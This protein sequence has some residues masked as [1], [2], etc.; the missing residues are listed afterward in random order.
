V[1]GGRPIRVRPARSAGEYPRFPPG[2]KRRRPLSSARSGYG[3]SHS[4]GPVRNR[5][6]GDAFEFPR[7]IGDNR[8]SFTQRMRGNEHVQRTDGGSLF[9][10]KGSDSAVFPGARGIKNEDGQC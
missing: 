7:V 9:F 5:Q 1:C 3:N 10:Q 6:S 4:F 8:H 2:S